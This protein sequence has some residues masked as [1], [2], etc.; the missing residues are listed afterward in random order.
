MRRRE[1]DGKGARLK[2]EAAATKATAARDS[3][4]LIATGDE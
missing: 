3:R 4:G 1:T 2:I